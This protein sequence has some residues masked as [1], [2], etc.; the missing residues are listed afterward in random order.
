MFVKSSTIL[1]ELVPLY[2][3]FIVSLSV[4][5]WL[6]VDVKTIDSRLGW[7]QQ[8]FDLSGDEVRNL[9]RREARIF[10]FGL[11]PL[12]VMFMVFEMKYGVFLPIALSL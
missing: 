3:L 12:Q 2:F 4:R 10:M 6:N 11:G 7:L 8:Q 9:I 5:Y 1:G